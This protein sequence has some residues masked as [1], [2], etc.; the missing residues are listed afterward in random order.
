MLTELAQ[1]GGHA[2]IPVDGQ[3]NLL[4]ASKVDGTPWTLAIAIDRTEATQPVSAMLKVAAGITLLCLI[5]AALL[6]TGT[7]RQQLRRLDLVRNALHDIAS[8]EGDLTRRLDAAGRDELAQIAQAFNQFVD[9]IAAVLMRIRESSES[10]RYT[11]EE[12]ASGNQ[13]LSERTERQANSLQ[14]TASAMEQLTSTVRQNADNAREAS[15]LAH[16]ASDVAVRGG[17]V[18]N[19]VVQT[20][21]NIDA[22]ARRIVDIIGVIDGIAFQTN[23]LALN[24]AVEAARAG[25]Q[26]RGF[27]VVA[28]EV[29]ALA[30]RSATAAKEI[31]ALIDESVAQVSNGSR[32]VHDAGSTMEQVV[33]SVRQVSSIVAEI[34]H[35]SQEQSSGI[36][37]IGEAVN[38]MDHGTQQNAA[39]VEE[40]AAA[41]QSLHQQAVQLA[42]AVAG[43]KVQAGSGNPLPAKRPML[44]PAVED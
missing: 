13:N 24:A 23:I 32:L 34:D 10:V 17:E 9:K 43:F 41:A 6:V 37:N 38:D 25:E 12:I 40:S 15:K 31:K 1:N 26:G 30:Q 27:A 42:E 3:A 7:M 20:M 33:Q 2:E 44:A 21:G 28:A 18:V 35:A 19:E 22:S 8:G 11:T 16:N 29:R 39:L 14:S 36:A 5:V 4:Y